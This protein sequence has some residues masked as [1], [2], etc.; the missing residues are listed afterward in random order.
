M[1]ALPGR[2]WHVV[3]SAIGQAASGRQ[4]G[5]ELLVQR[6]FSEPYR[7][8]PPFR[9]TF[10]CRVVRRFLPR[11]LRGSKSMR[12]SHWHFQGTEELQ[13]SRQQQAGILL[14]ANH[15]RTADPLI[16]GMLGLHVQQYFYY[17]VSYHL[18]K[19][20]RMRGWWMNRVGGYSILR[21]G[22]DREA[23]KATAQILAS[24]ER[25][26]VIFPEGT[27]FR[28][29][30]RLAPLQEGI[31]LMTRQAVKLATRPIVVH[32]VAIKYWQ[33][34]D[35]RP[36]LQ[37]RLTLVEAALGWHPQ[38]QLDLVGRI[39]KIG[40]AL[41][42]VK[43]VEHFGAPQPGGVD[44]RIQGL[45]N[46]H[47]ASLERQYLGRE[48]L[49][50]TLERI[51]RVRQT[52]V[53]RLP[54]AARDPVERE[55]LHQ[56]L[57]DLLLCENLSGH[58]LP[59]VQE[60]PSLER[61]AETVQ[62]I[63]E[64]VWDQEERPP[65]PVGAVVALGPAIDVRPLVNEGSR[66]RNEPDPLVQQLSRGIQTLLDQLVKQGPPSEWGC[67]APVEVPG[68]SPLVNGEGARTLMRPQ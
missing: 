22:A 34:E 64:T 5:V 48:H 20:N 67:P 56:G 38:K 2:S 4:A 17:V 16:M 60:R 45:I 8:I 15:C 14:T 52:L 27:W 50:W 68:P 24:A 29:N 37:Q 36:A 65:V 49:G 1:V 11:Q 31:I 66:N 19:Q 54:Q 43:E 42:A 58:S 10:W 62:R 40:S 39:E 51:R 44:E 55:R 32:P 13:K 9:S 41:V 47:V 28:Q 46:S 61:L 33:L 59:Y 25:P 12:V 35:P 21:E 3:P 18:F 63:E 30:D 7:F 6:Y 26:V 57:D 53:R 23:I